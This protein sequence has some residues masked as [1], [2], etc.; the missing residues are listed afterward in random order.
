MELSFLIHQ[1]SLGEAQCPVFILL[2]VGLHGATS[3]IPHQVLETLCLMW[4]TYHDKSIKQILL[5][6]LWASRTY[7]T[8]FCMEIQS[9]LDF[10]LFNSS[11]YAYIVIMREWGRERD[12]DTARQT[13]RFSVW[14]ICH[15]AGPK[16]RLHPSP[17]DDGEDSWGQI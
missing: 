8:L 13:D 3:Y 9:G 1:Q 14:A 7:T 4:L 15:S 5:C 12:T 2:L 16:S 11:N 10:S 17:E 6:W